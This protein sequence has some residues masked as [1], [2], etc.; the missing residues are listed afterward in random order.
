MAG[1][2]MSAVGRTLHLSSENTRK[3]GDFNV[4]SRDA[5]ESVVLNI[6]QAS[7]PDVAGPLLAQR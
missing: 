6:P 4:E 2:M 5:K 7:G 3:P 1:G